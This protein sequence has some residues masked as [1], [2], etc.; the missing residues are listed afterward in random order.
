MAG[1]QKVSSIVVAFSLHFQFI[2]PLALLLRWACDSLW[3]LWAICLRE[4]PGGSPFAFARSVRAASEDHLWLVAAVL[5]RPFGS[6]PGP[7]DR[8]CYSRALRLDPPAHKVSVRELET[9]TVNNG[10]AVL[11]GTLWLPVG[12][13]GPYPTVIIRNPYGQALS[14]DWGQILL[15]ERGYAVL[16]QDTRGRFGSDGD[17]VPVCMEKEKLSSRGLSPWSHA[18]AW[19]GSLARP[20]VFY[21]ARLRQHGIAAA[22]RCDRTTTNKTPS[23]NRP[24]SNGTPK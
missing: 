3:S 11:R 23:A 20:G 16:L 18:G 10:H 4:F 8:H 22:H 19:S 24:V 13:D 2:M 6:D 21:V 12:L 1:V 7:F 17:F 15:A 5:L 14:T 9:A